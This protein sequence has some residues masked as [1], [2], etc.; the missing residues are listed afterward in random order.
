MDT[1]MWNAFICQIIIPV[2]H[3]SELKKERA[4]VV[5]A[6]IKNI[7]INIGKLIFSQ[8]SLSINNSCGNVLHDDHYCAAAGLFL[9]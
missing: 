3:K 4:A 9:K 6:L 8:L 2:M 1:T 5:Y 7:S